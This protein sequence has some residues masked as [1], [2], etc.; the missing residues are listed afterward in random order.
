[1]TR[2]GRELLKKEEIRIR[3]GHFFKNPVFNTIELS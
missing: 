1:M 3:P 2:W